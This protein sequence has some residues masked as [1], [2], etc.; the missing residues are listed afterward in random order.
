MRNIVV[1][2]RGSRLA[3]LQVEEVLAALGERA[4]WSFELRVITTEGDRDRTTPIAGLGGRGVFVKAIEGSLLAGEVDLAVHSLKDMTTIETP[5]LVVA[6]VPRR[7]S[8]LDAVYSPT[9]QTLE[10]LGEAARVATGSPRRSAQVRA[11][12]PGLTVVDIRGNVDTRRQKVEQ[13][14]AGALI[15]A[16]AALDRLGFADSTTTHVLDAATM[17]PA[18][19]QGALACQVR[20][21]DHGL[22]ELLSTIEDPTSRAEVDAER[23]FLRAFGTGCQ[24]PIAALGRVSGDRLTLEGLVVSPDGCESVRVTASGS[25]DG[26][27]ALGAALAAEALREGAAALIEAG[28]P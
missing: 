5:G 22:A 28:R 16:Q 21:D 25:L 14:F 13:G 20:A 7:A 26:A 6:S 11:R 12:F 15:V 19:G 23:A 27:A 8:P 10:D 4:G 24:T 9:G 17:L 18:P 1:G 2:T 3:L